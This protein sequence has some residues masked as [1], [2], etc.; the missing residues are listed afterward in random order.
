MSSNGNISALLAL[1]AG[2]SPV[3]GKFPA[4]RPVTRSSDV[5]IDLLDPEQAGEKTIETPVIWHILLVQTET[6]QWWHHQRG[7]F[8]ALLALCAGIS[9]HRGQWC[10]ALVFSLICAW[11]NGWVNHREAGDLR[12]Y[13]AHYDVTVMVLFEGL[14]V[15]TLNVA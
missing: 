3:P 9:V 6:S 1:C 10:G 14:D 8:S 4:Q 15:I 12:S 5:F 2:N 11:I 7:P 13:G